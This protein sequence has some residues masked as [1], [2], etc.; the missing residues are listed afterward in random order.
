MI[1]QGHPVLIIHGWTMAG[2]V[3]ACDFEPVF[4]KKP[5]YRR[6]YVNLPGMGGSPMGKVK[7]L[8]SMLDVVSNFVENHILP[9]RFLLIG[10]SCGAYFARALAYK[11]ASDIDGLLLRVPLV[12]PENVKRDLDPFVPAISNDALLCSL[13]DADLK[14]LGYIPVHTPE[15]IDKFKR[16]F[17]KLIPPAIA[18]SDAEALDA[19]RNDPSRYKLSAPMHSPAAPF[20]NPTLILTGRQ[21]TVVG[22]RDAW[23]LVKCYPRATFVALDRADHGFPVDE[24]DLFAALV[25]NWLWRVEELRSSRPAA[26]LQGS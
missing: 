20:F 8:D 23:P 2:F 3:E 13:S 19:I 18:V 14:Q 21:D 22:I 9:S 15:Y 16:R 6:I 26:A 25:G 24:T 10:S 5:G 1:G 7:D 12:E 11:Y 4:T 17:D